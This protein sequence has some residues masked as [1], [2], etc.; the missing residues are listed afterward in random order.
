MR[1]WQDF[2]LV[3]LAL[4][5]AVPALGDVLPVVGLPAPAL[6]V[7]GAGDP[8]LPGGGAGYARDDGHGPHPGLLANVA[9]L[10]VLGVVGMLIAGRRVEKLLL[11]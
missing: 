9:Y 4:V 11:T 5:A 3:A 7:R 1:S 10:V 8:A 6:A 2:E